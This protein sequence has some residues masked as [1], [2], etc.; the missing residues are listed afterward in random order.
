MVVESTSNSTPGYISE[1]NENTNL[2][3]Y[4]HPS[5]HSSIIYNSQ[6]METTYVS[7]NTCIKD[8]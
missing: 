1:E 2:K 8:G 3:G 6:D 7:I 4:M 5:A